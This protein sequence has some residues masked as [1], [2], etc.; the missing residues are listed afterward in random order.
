MLKFAKCGRFLSFTYF[1]ATIGTIISAIT[2][3]LHN[4]FYK[5]LNQPRRNLAY[6]FDYIQK[7]P[8]YEITFFIQLTAGAYA[9]LG[10]YTVDSFVSI[11]V[12][13]V[14]AQLINLRIALSKLVDKLTNSSISSLTFKEGLTAIVEWHEHL[15]RYA[16][17]E[18]SAHLAHLSLKHPKHLCK[19]EQINLLYNIYTNIVQRRSRI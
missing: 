13:H 18:L 15:I 9:V 8:N 12:L 2:F 11:L 4:I 5:S 16:S 3:Y 6:R 7:S 1:V 10:N 17:S 19:Q 14:C